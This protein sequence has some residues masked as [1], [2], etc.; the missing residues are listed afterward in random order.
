MIN[1][2]LDNINHINNKPLFKKMGNKMAV[3]N[4]PL[5]G[6]IILEFTLQK[7]KLRNL[8]GGGGGGGVEDSTFSTSISK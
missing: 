1:R 4:R 2:K 3:G 8:G 5:S 7:H 6:D